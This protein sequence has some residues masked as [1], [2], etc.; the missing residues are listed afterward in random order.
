MKFFQ[1][2]PPFVRFCQLV[3]GNGRYVMVAAHHSDYRGHGSAVGAWDRTLAVFVAKTR[4]LADTID[5]L[6]K[7]LSWMASL[8]P[9]QVSARDKAR[10]FSELGKIYIDVGRNRAWVYAVPDP[11][12]GVLIARERANARKGS[13][14]WV[15]PDLEAFAQAAPRHDYVTES[16]ILG[17]GDRR[18][19]G[20]KIHFPAPTGPQIY[21]R[22]VTVKTWFDPA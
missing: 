13:G 9:G 5:D 18:R 20:R 2:L 19:D 4:E 21:R 17:L 3:N 6:E 8:V 1:D 11:E 12:V 22:Q 15:H 10:G 14:L 7:M 16:G